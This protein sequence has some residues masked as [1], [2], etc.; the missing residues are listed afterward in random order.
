MCSDNVYRCYM[1]SKA[2]QKK[3]QSS[4]S[5]QNCAVRRE[6]ENW[7][8]RTVQL[9]QLVQASTLVFGRHCLGEASPICHRSQSVVLIFVILPDHSNKPLIANRETEILMTTMTTMVAVMWVRFLSLLFSFCSRQSCLAGIILWP[10][11]SFTILFNV[12]ADLN[13]AEQDHHLLLK[14]TLGGDV[15]NA[16][17]RGE[18]VRV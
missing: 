8:E 10:L 11:M 12:L 18:N 15:M 4:Q 5:P 7:N 9:V 16:R 2:Y 14:C 13:L 1:L 3:P 17:P 6:I